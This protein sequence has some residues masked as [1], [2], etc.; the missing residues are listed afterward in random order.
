MGY[1]HSP[2]ERT[3]VCYIVQILQANHKLSWPFFED[4]YTYVS[5]IFA[6][7]HLDSPLPSKT[8]TFQILYSNLS[9]LLL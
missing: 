4:A 5:P 6:I 1:T 3:Y 9:I 8:L 7:V 2:N